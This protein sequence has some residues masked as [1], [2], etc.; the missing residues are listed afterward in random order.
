MTGVLDPIDTQIP[1]S[2]AYAFARQHGVEAWFDA[3][4]VHPRTRKDRIDAN[5][6]LKPR[7]ADRFQRL[8]LLIERATQ[9]FDNEDKAL[10]WLTREQSCFQ[11]AT[12]LD[13]AA[14]ERNFL[15]VLD[16]LTRIEYGISA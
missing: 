12:P 2:Q 3:C 9:A 5:E 10:H 1:T 11:G 16:H 15:A 7:E 6:L 8:Q 13:Y 14:W 4:V